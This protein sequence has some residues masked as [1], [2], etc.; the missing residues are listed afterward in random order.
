MIP[1][2]SETFEQ[3]FTEIFYHCFIETS[4]VVHLK[5][6]GDTGGMWIHFPAMFV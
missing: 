1:L 6:C 4:F 2:V 5:W 3:Y